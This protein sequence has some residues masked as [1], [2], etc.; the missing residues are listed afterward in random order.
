MT[1]LGILI[2]ASL[3]LGGLGLFGFFYT[4]RKDQYDDPKG[5]AERIL[6]GDYD[7]HPKP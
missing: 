5:D 4:L 7:D 6:S 2:P 3:L 1:V